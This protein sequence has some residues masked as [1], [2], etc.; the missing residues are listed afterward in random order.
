MWWPSGLGEQPLYTVQVSLT[1]PSTNVVIGTHRTTYFIT[2]NPPTVDTRRIAF[3]VASLVTGNDT[4][5]E[6]V[7]NNQNTDGSDSF[8]EMW[9]INGQAIFNRGANVIPMDDMEGRYSALAHRQMVLSARDGMMNT[10]RIW[11]GGMNPSLRPPEI[12]LFILL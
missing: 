9:R 12:L 6:Y 3:R 4:N 1:N 5:P 2:P 10:L 11:G 7:K 8:G